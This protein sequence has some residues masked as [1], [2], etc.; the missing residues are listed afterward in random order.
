MDQEIK[1]IS[2]EEINPELELLKKQSA[3]YL[4]G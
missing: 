4:T 1:E 2:P 3:D